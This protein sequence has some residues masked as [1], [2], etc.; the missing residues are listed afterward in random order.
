MY[1]PASVHP[2]VPAAPAATW[3]ALVSLLSSASLS[4]R[5]CALVRAPMPG[6]RLVSLTMSRGGGCGT[7]DGVLTMEGDFAVFCFGFFFAIYVPFV[8]QC[9]PM[10]KR[11]SSALSACAVR[12]LEPV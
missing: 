10:D 12:R 4:C 8:G 5:I 6:L 9:R 11:G 3:L 2:T 7:M 1:A